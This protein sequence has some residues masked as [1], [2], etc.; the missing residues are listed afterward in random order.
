M[1]G[2]LKRLMTTVN[3]PGKMIRATIVNPIKS[4][5]S[6]VLMKLSIVIIY[7]LH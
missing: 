6:V 2:L 3:T 7:W 5:L 1:Y 4:V